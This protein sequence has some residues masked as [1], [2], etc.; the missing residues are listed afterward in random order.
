MNNLDLPDI[1][2]PEEAK[3]KLKQS[4]VSFVD[5]CAKFVTICDY[6][7][8]PVHE[9]RTLP[10]TFQEGYAKNYALLKK[11]SIDEF[12]YQISKFA[13]L[14]LEFVDEVKECLEEYETVLN[15][16]D[17]SISEYDRSCDLLAAK[18]TFT[19][20]ENEINITNKTIAQERYLETHPMDPDYD[21]S[22]NQAQIEQ[23]EKED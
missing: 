10:V 3:A 6:Y 12:C 20:L 5:S 7:S 14:S 19:D 23:M 11:A 8:D 9:N 22:M 18:D 15:Y 4:R 1:E 21:P 17:P 2:T 13:A 16:E